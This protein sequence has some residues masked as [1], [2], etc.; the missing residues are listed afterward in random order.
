MRV[1][2]QRVKS[3]SVSVDGQVKSSIQGG[4]LVLLG[5]EHADLEQDADWL[6][7]KLSKL[8][9]F[10]DEDGVMNRS[11]QEAEGDFLVVSQF[12]LHASYKKG[13]RPSYINSAKPEFAQSMYEYFLEEL[14]KVSNRPVRSGVFGADMKV[15]LINDGPVTIWMDSKNK[16]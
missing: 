10:P 1:L 3:A 2:L 12:T 6:C 11:I 9:I 4:M 14:W 13:N 15:E 5:I 8:R 16:E 7:A